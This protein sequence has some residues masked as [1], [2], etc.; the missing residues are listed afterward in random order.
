[1]SDSL[2]PCG[3]CPPGSSVHGSLQAGILEWVAGSFSRESSRP[4]DRTQ[5]SRIASRRFK[6]WATREAHFSPKSFIKGELLFS[7]IY[8]SKLCHCPPISLIQQNKGLTSLDLEFQ[9][10]PLLALCQSKSRFINSATVMDQMPCS[11]QG[12]RGWVSVRVVK[13]GLSEKRSCEQGPEG[14]R[15]QPLCSAGP[16]S[17]QMSRL[18]FKEIKQIAQDLKSMEWKRWESSLSDFKASHLVTI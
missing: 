16:H 10:S 4:R 13:K 18:R 14:R 9:P 1:M 12:S 6:L 11:M 5:V 7:R 8:M 15:A 2:R 3:L 17:S